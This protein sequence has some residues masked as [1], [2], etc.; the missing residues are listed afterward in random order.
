MSMDA[1]TVLADADEASGNIHFADGLFGFPGCKRFDLRATARPSFYWMQSLDEPSVSFV[2]V[3]P[4]DFVSDYVA[5]IADTDVARLAAHA[6]HE[7]AVLTI[8]TLPSD[9]DQPVTVNL[10]APIAINV[11]NGSA[12][13]VVLNDATYGMRFPLPR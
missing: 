8:A 9:A 12:R 13:Q 10:Q 6:T 7:V 11:A 1:A 3:D 2:L 5:D 4:F